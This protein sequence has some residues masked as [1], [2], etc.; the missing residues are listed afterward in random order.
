MTS[1]RPIVCILDP[2]HE[3]AVAFLSEHATVHRHDS[4][5]IATWPK[6]AEAVIVRNS[7]VD[8]RHIA[9]A[10]SL[11]VIGKHGAGTDN[12]DTAA[13][14]AAGIAVLTTPG[15]NADSVA[16]LAVGMALLLIRDIGRHTA[17]LRRGAP[18]QDRDRVGYELAEL[19]AGVLGFG[20]IGRAVSRRLTCGFGAKVCAFDP[21]LPAAAALPPGV[22]RADDLPALLRRSRLLFLHLPLTPETRHLIGSEEIAAMPA[23]SFIVN[24]ARGGIVDENALAAGL[25]SGHLAGAAS[26][27]FEREPPPADHPLLQFDRF[28]ATPHLGASTNIGLRRVGLAIARKVLEGLRRPAH[29]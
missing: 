26:D 27:V 18:L 13:A 1:D 11:L 15:E 24:C 2:V 10:R 6:I 19:P 29:D 23:G 22:E 28:V 17:A 12:I 20:A 25:R 8:R 9:R 7:V 3:D 4:A 21:G 16:D 5:E 14:A